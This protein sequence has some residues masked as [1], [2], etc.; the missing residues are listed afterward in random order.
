M[1]SAAAAADLA[2]TVKAL[3]AVVA[4]EV[5]PAVVCQAVRVQAVRD[6]LAVAA[7]VEL[8]LAAVAAAAAQ[9]VLEV[10]REL[11]RVALADQALN[12]IF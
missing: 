4:V 12:V 3:L 5:F 7:T 1:R 2:I 9:V 11:T 6:L 10:S 8:Q